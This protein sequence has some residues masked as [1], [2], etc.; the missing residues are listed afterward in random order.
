MF[1]CSHSPSTSPSTPIHLTCPQSNLNV[2]FYSITLK[3]IHIVCF[4]SSQK[5]VR[6]KKERRSVY[7][8]KDGELNWRSGEGGRD[9]LTGMDQAITD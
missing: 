9:R 4:K 7:S 8:E 5:T 2:C 6:L 1:C 3:D